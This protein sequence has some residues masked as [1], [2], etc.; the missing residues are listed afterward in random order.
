MQIK[1]AVAIGTGFAIGVIFGMNVSD[2]EKEKFARFIKKKLIFALTGEKWEPKKKTVNYN[3]NYYKTYKELK[4][5]KEYKPIIS[6]K[7]LLACESEIDAEL[8]LTDLTGYVETYGTVSVVDLAF[9]QG[10]TVDFTWNRYYWTKDDILNGY[11][12]GSKVVLCNPR[13]EDTEEETN[14]KKK[15]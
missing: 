12:K 6:E 4:K 2:N 1:T 10:K 13:V 15:G 14:K 7:E 5:E 11:V 8:L 9:M 3:R